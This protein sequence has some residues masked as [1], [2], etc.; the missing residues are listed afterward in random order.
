MIAKAKAKAK[1][2]AKAK[3]QK[4]RFDCKSKGKFFASRFSFENFQ[5]SATFSKAQRVTVAMGYF[6]VA[7]AFTVTV[8][9]G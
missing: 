9:M 6:T 2:K 8:A 3:K 5:G 1:G 4:E 7:V